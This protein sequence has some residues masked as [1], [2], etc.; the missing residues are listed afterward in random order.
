VIGQE[1]PPAEFDS[2]KVIVWS[3]G[4]WNYVESAAEKYG[5]II[6]QKPGGRPIA[7][8]EHTLDT[9]TTL[10]LNKVFETFSDACAGKP[11]DTSGLFMLTG[12][13]KK[14][15]FSIAAQHANT[16]LQRLI[17]D[18]Q[19]GLNS[20]ERAQTNRKGSNLSDVAGEIVLNKSDES[21]TVTISDQSVTPHTSNEDAETRR[22][23]EMVLRLADMTQREIDTIGEALKAEC[24]KQE[25]DDFEA[26]TWCVE[27]ALKIARRTAETEGIPPE[28]FE[29]IR[30]TCLARWPRDY[31]MQNHC[32]ES[33]IW[34]FKKLEGN[35]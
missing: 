8:K 1:K 35:R 20:N 6:Y 32:E 7:A 29:E 12:R 34:G 13:T 2:I 28:T 18:H 26:Q 21:S 14:L 11:V 22:L 10:E 15:F 3:D 23:A 33:Q 24:A 31:R 27:R 4:R 16:C 30:A 25:P 9:E 5:S 19:Q 17:E